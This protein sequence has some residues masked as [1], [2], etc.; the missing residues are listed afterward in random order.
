MR[1]LLS[2]LALFAFA[3]HAAGVVPMSAAEK[4]QKLARAKAL[5]EEAARIETDADARLKADNEVCYK[6][7]LVSACLEEA[8]TA[9]TQ[10]MRESSRRNLEGSELER[11]VKRNEVAVRDAQRAAEAPKRAAE[12]EAQ[13]EAFRSSEAKKA[14]ARAAKQAEK[15]QQAAAGRKKRAE[16]Q[17]RH[18]KKLEEYAQK[19][20]KADEK[21]RNREAAEAARKQGAGS[22]P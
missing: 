8:K 9:H 6:K 15:A 11:A 10:R 21:R 22:N 4:E 18:Q 5:K 2:F 13:G 16:D 14:D 7:I 19:R 3:A 12:Q 20:A 17:A 1:L